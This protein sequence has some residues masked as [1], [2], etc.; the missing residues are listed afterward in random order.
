VREA[1]G[2]AA[3]REGPSIKQQQ[4]EEVGM[5]IP[6]C[7]LTGL[8]AIAA[9]LGA[10]PLGGAA[11]AAKPLEEPVTV[12]A[13]EVTATSA[14]LNGVLNP[15]RKATAGWYFTY[16]SG[17]C[18]EA[19]PAGGEV[20]GKA[21]KVAT[22]VAGLI[23]NTEYTFCMHATNA[24]GEEAEG[25]A[26]T[27]TTTALAPVIDSERASNLAAG[28]AMLEA[29]VNPENEPTTSCSFEYGP[30]LAY[31]TTVPCRQ[32]PFEGVADHLASAEATGLSSNELVHL[33]AVIAN[34]TG[35]THGLDRTVTMP[36][37]PLVATGTA[38]GVTTSAAALAGTVDPEGAETFY[39]FAYIEDAG[40]QAA[41]AA[42][43]HDPYAAGSTTAYAP[44]PAGRTVA[45]VSPVTV[46]GLQ[47]S[48]TYHYA[49]LAVNAAGSSIGGDAMFTTAAAS[50]PPA[51]GTQPQPA[52]I[53][54]QLAVPATQPTLANPLAAAGATGVLGSTTHGGPAPSSAQRLAAALK[55]CRRGPHRQRPACERAARRRYGA[56]RAGHARRSS[57]ARAVAAP[58]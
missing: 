37:V 9:L 46:D 5:P 36:G 25:E 54:Y 6:R 50:A 43:A 44:L 22:P 14:K 57:R 49:L 15:G 56:H 27:F 53:P 16:G 13:T 26:L 20:T 8:A 19:T 12:A 35:V 52:P 11:L 42:H 4:Q 32:V 30:T 3:A 55:A 10:T 48:T 38:Q 28:T 33:R 1:Q 18:E 17:G 51:E 21:V 29:R 47:P 41:V 7:T 31:G 40:Y 39:A 23:P 24:E 58:R 34:A 2:E 45:A